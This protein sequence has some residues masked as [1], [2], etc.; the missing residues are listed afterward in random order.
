MELDGGPLA[1]YAGTACRLAAFGSSLR[2]AWS[3]PRR[4][5]SRSRINGSVATCTQL[6]PLATNPLVRPNLRTNPCIEW[7]D[8]VAEDSVI[9]AQPRLLLRRGSIAIDPLRL[10]HSCGVTLAPVSRSLGA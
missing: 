3:F 9:A 4:P 8:T 10:V 7:R 5:K 6:G 2:R 1:E